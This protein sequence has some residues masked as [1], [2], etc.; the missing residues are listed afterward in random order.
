MNRDFVQKHQELRIYQL[1]FEN[2]MQVFELVRL[3]PEE[4]KSLLT[5]QLIRASRSVCAN[6]AEGWLKR[7][8]K[9]SFVA[10]LTDA[11]AEAA[12]MQTW[13]EFS[14]LCGYLDSELGQELHGRYNEI[15]AG[16]TR[17]VDNADAWVSS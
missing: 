8:Y 15:L 1:A 7:R 17:L 5:S 11:A 6:I 14:V 2:A 4:E 13:L 9:G 12:E 10:K 16:I 3:F